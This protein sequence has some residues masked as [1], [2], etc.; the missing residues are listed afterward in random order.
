MKI[1]L[2][3][4]LL[5]LPLAASAQPDPFEAYEASRRPAA[6]GPAAAAIPHTG[7]LGEGSLLLGLGAVFNFS[8]AS[9]E[10][11]DGSEVDNSTLF[12]R[13]NPSIGYFV[14]DHVELGFSPGMLVRQLDRGGSD[15][16][17]DAMWLFELTGRYF[18]P[19]TPNFSL[20]GGGGLGGA[21]GG[22]SR[23]LTITDAN[24]RAREVTEETTTT[25][26]V[27]G[28]DLGAAYMIRPTLQLRAGVDWT[29]LI[30]SESV[31]SLSKD[32]AVSTANMGLGVGLHGAF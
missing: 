17:T 6:R 24:G 15:T 16:T 5:A 21:Y 26:F 30:G 28:A 25:A 27:L 1:R 11:D 3:L 2:T 4:A 22:S 12:L 29:W 14:T 9:N 13:L 20:Y 31:G 19:V 8:S 23:G 10:L 32:L 7:P 18:H